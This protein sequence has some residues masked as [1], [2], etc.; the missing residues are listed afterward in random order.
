MFDTINKT[1][2]IAPTE[3]IPKQSNLWHVSSTGDESE[4]CASL[5]YACTLRST[6]SKQHFVQNDAVAC[7]MCV[8]RVFLCTLFHP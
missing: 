5:G 8:E 4:N 1:N 7:A 3:I 2:Q 6:L